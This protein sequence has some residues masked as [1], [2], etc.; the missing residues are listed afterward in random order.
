MREAIANG[1]KAQIEFWDKRQLVKKLIKQ[2]VWC[3]SIPAVDFLIN[4][5]VIQHYWQNNYKT[6]GCNSPK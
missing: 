1:D 6:H 4:V 2:F 5:L 3:Y